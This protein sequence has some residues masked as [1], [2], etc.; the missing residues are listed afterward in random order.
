MRLTNSM[1]H[2]YRYGALSR[3]TLPGITLAVVLDLCSSQTHS[4]MHKS[5]FSLL[6][7]FLHQS[8]M[9]LILRRIFHGILW[10]SCNPK[11]RTLSTY[12]HNNSDII[13]SYMY[14]AQVDCVQ[15]H[16]KVAINCWHQGNFQEHILAHLIFGR[17]E[18]TKL[19]Q[20]SQKTTR[21][22]V[23]APEIYCLFLR[24]RGFVRLLIFLEINWLEIL[25]EFLERLA[26]CSQNTTCMFPVLLHKLSSTKQHGIDFSC[27][28]ILTLLD[29]DGWCRHLNKMQLWGSQSS[30]SACVK[31]P[32]K[33]TLSPPGTIRE[34]ACLLKS[35][36][37][38][39]DCL[40]KPYSGLSTVC[41]E[42][43]TLVHPRT[44]FSC[45]FLM[46]KLCNKLPTHT[47]RCINN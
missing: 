5:C 10:V 6:N 27:P 35:I 32:H 44:C 20:N 11:Q 15:F 19:R 7:M 16:I 18:V 34:A 30:R 38:K 4:R 8:L 31:E 23:F 25:Y 26:S 28:T 3:I 1:L 21:K 43:E 41:F 33:R 14:A 47:H 9:T 36:T 40:V 2:M 24:W 42:V 12:K 13:Q 29:G 45:L 22:F 46:F 37:Q 39:R 17:R